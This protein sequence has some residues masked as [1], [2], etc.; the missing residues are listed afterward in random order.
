[1]HLIDSHAHLDMYSADELPAVLA[2]AYAA[3]VRTIL[4]IGIGDGPS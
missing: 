1:M 3:D 4:A 2:R